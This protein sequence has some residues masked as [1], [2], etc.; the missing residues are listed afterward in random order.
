[1]SEEIKP[2]VVHQ[3]NRSTIASKIKR[4]NDHNKELYKMINDNNKEIA[5]QASIIANIIH[6]ESSTS[7]IPRVPSAPPTYLFDK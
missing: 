5:L 2:N 6:L 1:M 4:L 7:Y 3:E